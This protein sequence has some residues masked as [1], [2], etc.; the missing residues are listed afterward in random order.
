MKYVCLDYDSCAWYMYLEEKD[1]KENLEQVIYCRECTALAVLVP[2]DFN[3]AS[4]LERTQ[5]YILLQEKE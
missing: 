4:S 1:Y 3:I 2:N 5:L